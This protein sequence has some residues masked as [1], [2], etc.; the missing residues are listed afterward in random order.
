MSVFSLR[1]YVPGFPI[2]SFDIFDGVHRLCT[3][4]FSA[5]AA[6]RKGGWRHHR[7]TPM[8][9]MSFENNTNRLCIVCASF[10]HVC[11]LY[12]IVC[13]SDVHHI[14]FFCR[15]GGLWTCRPY[16]HSYSPVRVKTNVNRLCIVCAG[17]CTTVE[18]MCKTFNFFFISLGGLWT[19]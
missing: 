19:Y 15:G 5:I 17:L 6:S 8:T 7:P 2:S 14:F 9:Q 10:V 1:V 4:H 3:H 13:A 12:S 11:A 16:L 18:R